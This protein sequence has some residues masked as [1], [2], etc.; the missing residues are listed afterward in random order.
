MGLVNQSGVSQQT[1]C[2]MGDFG[3]KVGGAPKSGFNPREYG[4]VTK[5]ITMWRLPSGKHAKNYGKSPCY[6]W[7]NQLLM[8][9]VGIIIPTD[10]LIFF[11][12]VG[13]PPTSH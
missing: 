6:S 3:S 7:V 5:P 10:E 13:I 8:S 2:R 11:R 4:R 1:V 9:V 12:G